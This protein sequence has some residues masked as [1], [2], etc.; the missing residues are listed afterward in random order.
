MLDRLPELALDLKIPVRGAQAADPLMRPFVVVILHPLPY[1]LTRILEALE[2]CSY[3]KLQVD[4][5]PEPLDL[6]Q[7]HR[8]VRL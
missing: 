3:E 6:A 7:C 8:V 2:L 1:P 4:C 5:F